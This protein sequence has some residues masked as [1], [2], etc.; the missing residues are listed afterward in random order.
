[1]LKF[2]PFGQPLDLSP[3]PCGATI[4]LRSWLPSTGSSDGK[5]HGFFP[6]ENERKHML[7]C[8]CTCQKKEKTLRCHLQESSRRRKGSQIWILL[9][10]KCSSSKTKLV[11]LSG[12]IFLVGHDRGMVGQVLKAKKKCRTFDFGK[13]DRRAFIEVKKRT[14][15]VANVFC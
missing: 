5:S 3:A 4:P 15:E 8:I 9:S 2:S 10:I 11:T 6:P 13:L 7:P 12:R 1:M 14:S